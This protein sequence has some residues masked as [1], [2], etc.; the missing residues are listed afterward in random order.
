MN[1]FKQIYYEMKHQ[2]MMTWV[3]ISGTALAIFLVMSFI[4][5]DQI[6]TVEVAPETN[7]SRILLGKGIHI[8]MDSQDGS[9]MG[10]NSDFIKKIY[11][12]LE[13]VELISYIRDGN[14][15]NT[16]SVPGQEGMT[17]LPKRIDA[18]FWKMYD[19]KF[20]DGRPFNQGEVDS[21][22]KVIVL[23]R[24]AARKLFGEENVTGRTVE[25][26]MV[27]YQVVG[28]VDDVHP[29]MNGTF[30]H[31][32]VPFHGADY[33]RNDDPFCGGTNVRLLLKEGT[34]IASVKK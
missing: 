17:F 31:F 8:K 15:N 4:V 22:A 32:Y 11:E 2:K 6:N 7:R 9:T 12:G 18:N 19:F 27:D 5:A 25:V 1:Y 20:I 24:S 10:W 30:A 26:N 29:L 28:V 16:L 13:G 23:T 33:D 21:N 34:D 3:S 14:S